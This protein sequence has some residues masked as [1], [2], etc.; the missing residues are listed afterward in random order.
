MEM[1]QLG[2]GP[3]KKTWDDCA[4][5]GAGRLFMVA[6]PGRIGCRGKIWAME[7]ASSEGGAAWSHGGPESRVEV[8]GS[9]ATGDLMV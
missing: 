5:R 3:V 9:A 8:E 4:H 6:C 7:R 1:W 2:G